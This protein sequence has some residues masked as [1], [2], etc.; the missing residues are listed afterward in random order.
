MA[1]SFVSKIAKQAEP[2]PEREDER[3]PLNFLTSQKK[4][5]IT[6]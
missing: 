3:R 4:N 6:C 2:L 1:N 5:I